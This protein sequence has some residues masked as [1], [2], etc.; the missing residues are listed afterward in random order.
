MGFELP[1]FLP[2]SPIDGQSLRWGRGCSWFTQGWELV[3]L[4]S[5]NI[6]HQVV[7]AEIQPYSLSPGITTRF[8]ETNRSRFSLSPGSFCVH[9]RVYVRPHT[10]YIAFWPKPVSVFGLFN[11]TGFN[12]SS[13]VLTIPPTLASSPVDTTRCSRSS[14]F[15]YQFFDC[16][17]VVGR[18]YTAHYFAAILRRVLPVERQVWSVFQQPNNYSVNFTS[19]HRT[20]DILLLIE[21]DLYEYYSKY[22]KE[23]V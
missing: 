16:E 19:H 4:T 6:E 11:I 9:D 1:T 3:V 23:T 10:S 22:L 2:A 7:K 15:S 17:T 5:P 14:R 20:I 8:K 12:E 21:L 13:R 18:L